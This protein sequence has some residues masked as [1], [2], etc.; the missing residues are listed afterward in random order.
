[1]ILVD[2]AFLLVVLTVT[3]EM[4]PGHEAFVAAVVSLRAQER[5][6]P[7]TNEMRPSRV[8]I[9]RSRCISSREAACIDAAT[10][11]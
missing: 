8:V 4:R 5:G 11:R 9:A 6:S 10:L 7:T 3:H 2:G 1:V